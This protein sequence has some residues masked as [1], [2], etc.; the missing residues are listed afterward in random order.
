MGTLKIILNNIDSPNDFNLFYKK[1]PSVGNL[2]TGFNFYNSYSGGT[3]YIEINNLDDFGEQYWFKIEDVTN[4]SF[5]IENIAIF[6]SE[7]C[8]EPSPTPTPTPTMGTTPTPTPTIG[9]TSTPTPTMAE[10]TATSTPTL[11]STPGTT[12]TPTPTIVPTSTPTLTSTPTMDRTITLNWVYTSG[13][14]GSTITG[15]D[16]PSRYGYWNLELSTPLISGEMITLVFDIALENQAEN[17]AQQISD[18]GLTTGTT[19]NPIINALPEYYY[20]LF[21]GR[22]NQSSYTTTKNY[23]LTPGNDQVR[24]GLEAKIDGDFDTTGTAS[25]TMTS[26]TAY[27]WGTV[28]IIAPSTPY[29]FVTVTSNT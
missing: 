17:A 21:T 18:Y 12:S 24:L 25:A 7:V 13:T 14:T 15:D 28:N 4:Q 5:I 19:Q 16:S 23:T 26:F 9:L 27:G 8:P 29:P 22:N 6:E 10:P 1:G 11:T 20:G 3:T 2:Y